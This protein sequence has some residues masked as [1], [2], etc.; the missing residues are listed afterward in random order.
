M[1]QIHFP[2]VVGVGSTEAGM[3][4]L[5][6]FSRARRDLPYTT[7]WDGQLYL[8]GP[9]VADFTRPVE[10]MD[11]ARLSD[12]P[13]LRALTYTALGLLLGSGDHRL[14][15]AIGLPV[16]VMSDV[17]LAHA[18]LRN[19]R[20]WMVGAH[21]FTVN[22]AAVQ[23]SIE[24]VQILAQPAG[25]F[26][27]WGL[28]DLGKWNRA[29]DDIKA[30]VAVCDLGFNTLDLFVV[31]N[32]QIVNRFTGGDTVGMRRASEM[33]CQT[34]QRQYGLKLSLQEADAL[35]RQRRPTLLISGT[36]VDL[37]GAARQALDSAAGSVLAFL[38][39][40]WGNGRQFGHL[41]F[42]GGGAEALRESLLRAYPYGVILPEPVTANALGLARYARRV[43]S[44]GQVVGFDPGFGGIKAVAL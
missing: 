26:F 23:L 4:S 25:A 39:S 30:L 38:E 43:W 5:G 11:F 24:Q 18:T 42:T 17:D 41:L 1:Q 35:L 28:N 34:L 33:F 32:G 8:V 10:R 31:Q 2:S 16:E 44:A 9:R 36:S 13:E 29:T 7:A 14:S 6:T 20:S 15:L 40:R 37:T 3:L 12:G 19:L 27:A 21:A 22:E